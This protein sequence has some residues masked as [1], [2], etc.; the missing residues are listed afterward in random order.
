MLT[1]IDDVQN[2]IVRYL[3]L[4]EYNQTTNISLLLYLQ[5]RTQYY[6]LPQIQD[7]YS[8]IIVN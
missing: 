3:S 1:L 6:Y 2:I 7:Y 5:L 4:L 8:R